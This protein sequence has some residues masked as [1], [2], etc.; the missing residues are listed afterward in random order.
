MGWP[1][2]VVASLTPGQVWWYLGAEEVLVS[3]DG[4]LSE[5]AREAQADVGRAIQR[6]AARCPGR[7]EFDYIKEV[8]PELGRMNSGG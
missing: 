3:P 1:P 6:L 2:D 4:E 5:S 8:L 7:T